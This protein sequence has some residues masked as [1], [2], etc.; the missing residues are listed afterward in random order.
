MAESDSPT[1]VRVIVRQHDGKHK[2][3]EHLSDL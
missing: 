3:L 2:P 1:H